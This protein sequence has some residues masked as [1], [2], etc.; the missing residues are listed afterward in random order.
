MFHYSHNEITIAQWE[1]R[2]LFLGID[3]SQVHH[4]AI[5]G[6]KFL[7]NHW[8]DMYGIEVGAWALIRVYTIGS[9]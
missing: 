2:S 8:F 3:Y 1:Y 6:L 5:D 9:P 7:V 4:S